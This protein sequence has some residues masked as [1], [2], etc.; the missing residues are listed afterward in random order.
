MSG[1]GSVTPFGTCSPL[2]RGLWCREGG[3]VDVAWLVLLVT[4]PGLEAPQWA[5]Q[6]ARL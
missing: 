5:L 1:A 2:L 3:G 4:S 6:Q